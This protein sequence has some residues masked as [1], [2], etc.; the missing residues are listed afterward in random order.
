[1]T[2]PAH[3]PIAATV[4]ALLLLSGGAMA[5]GGHPDRPDVAAEE[6]EAFF[7]QIRQEATEII[8]SGEFERINEWTARN[9]ADGAVL[10]ASVAMLQD[11]ERKGSAD[12]SLDKEDILRFGGMFAG[13][14]QQHAIK[15]YSLQVEVSEVVPHG[16]GAATARVRW[17]E[18]FTVDATAAGPGGA[19][20]G[21]P[22]G[23]TLAIE[24]EA[25][26]SHLVQ[27]E[28]EQWALGL[29][30]CTAELHL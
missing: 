8:R 23:A 19:A 4:A 14:M 29:S 13:A 30:T 28:G 26:C 15:D 25:V 12:V 20:A 24:A 7:Q 11:G 9:I 6:I 17:T 22:E 16:P 27:R 5:Q 18:S 10:Q 1:M 3:A 21:R 2:F